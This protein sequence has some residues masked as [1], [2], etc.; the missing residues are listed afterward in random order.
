MAVSQMSTVTQ[1]NAA[2]SEESASAAEELASQAEEL[3]NMIGT[4]KLTAAA[5]LR[6]QGST[7]RRAG[8]PRGLA[9]VE[10]HAVGWSA[11]HA[12]S[13]SGGNG[14]AAATGRRRPRR[15]RTRSAHASRKPEE[16]IP[17]DDDETPRLLG[18]RGC[19][20][21]STTEFRDVVYDATGHQP[22]PDARRR[23][24]RRAWASACGRSA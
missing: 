20:A 12:R 14:T 17:L 3:M 1:Q 9:H 6:V 11:A 23:W 5:S 21:R 15:P 24:S 13:A 19:S 7:S 8:A 10:S 18:T 22:R 16:V 4:F 2:N